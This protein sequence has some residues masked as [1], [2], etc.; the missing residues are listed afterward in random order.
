MKDRCRSILKAALPLLMLASFSFPAKATSVVMLTDD[1]LILDSRVILTGTVNTVFSAWN[2][3]HN[4]IYTY[5]EV[6]PD[7]F[8]K[9][10]LNTKRVVLKQLG[11]TVGG[12]GM[13]LSGQP[14]FV[15]GQ[16]VLL[17][18]NTAPDGTLRTAHIFM[19]AFS[20]TTNSATQSEWV[21]RDVDAAEV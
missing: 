11:G 4:L 3:E 17:Y 7:R 18:L 5:V 20:I 16:R 2:D 21:T 6:R 13:R 9:G 1:E 12:S 8:L 14:E 15:S 10:D 19:G